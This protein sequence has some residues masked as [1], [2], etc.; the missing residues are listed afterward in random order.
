M[1]RGHIVAYRTDASRELSVAYVV[2]NDKETHSI[3]AHQ[4]RTIWKGTG[5][6]HM[7]EYLTSTAEGSDVTLTPSDTPVKIQIWYRML[8]RLVEVYQDGRMMHGDST[9]LSRGGWTFRMTREDLKRGVAL[10]AVLQDELLSIP[11]PHADVAKQTAGMVRIDRDDGSYILTD[12]RDA[13]IR[14]RLALDGHIFNIA[15]PAALMEESF[16]PLEGSQESSF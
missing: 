5:I 2:Y 11:E 1:T 15:D 7:R 6:V 8:V 3:Q 10:A 12:C 14:Q 13:S 4:C 16:V 9:A